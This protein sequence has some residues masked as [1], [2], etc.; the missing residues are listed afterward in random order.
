MI[1]INFASKHYLR[2]QKNIA[3]VENVPKEYT[4]WKLSHF[5]RFYIS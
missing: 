1:F 5:E 2:L 3:E 4:H